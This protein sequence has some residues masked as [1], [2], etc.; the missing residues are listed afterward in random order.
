M[1]EDQSGRVFLDYH[2]GHRDAAAHQD[3]DAPRFAIP[4]A[5]QPYPRSSIPALQAAVWVR[6]RQSDQFDAFDLAV[7]EAFFTWTED[8]GDPDVLCQ[9]GR[10]CGLDP[11]GLRDVL[12]GA[13]LRPTVLQE[14]EEAFRLGIRGIPAVVIPGRPPIVGAVRYADLQQAV[15]EALPGC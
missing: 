11:A 9:V 1:T 7:F 3:T 15:R 8:I 12:E 13:S 4:P 10:E 2:R 6:D 14:T 5:G